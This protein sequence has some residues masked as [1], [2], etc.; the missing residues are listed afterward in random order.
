MARWYGSGPRMIWSSSRIIRC[1]FKMMGC[2]S[3]MIQCGSR[4]T[5]CGFQEETLR[6]QGR[7]TADSVG[8]QIHRKKSFSIFPSPARMSLTK[9]FLGGNKLYFTSLF[10]PRESLLSD[11][12]A[13][14]GNIEKLFLRCIVARWQT[15]RKATAFAIFSFQSYSFCGNPVQNFVFSQTK[16][17]K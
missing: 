9:I 11:I 6:I 16:R 1:G 7:F 12:P 15:M 2:C 8:G 13:E 17:R 10:P 3:R 14:D 5:R 4:M